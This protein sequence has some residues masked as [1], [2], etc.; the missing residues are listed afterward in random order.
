MIFVS[1]G[2][3][4]K[5]FKRLLDAIEKQIDKGNIKEEV[6]VQ[7]GYTKYKSDNMKIFDL[8]SMEDFQKYMSSCDLLI[9]HGGVGSILDGLKHNKKIIAAPRLKEFGEHT[10]DHQL[11]IINS[12]YEKGYIL[13][14]E[15]F[16][17]LDKVLL[18]VKSFKPKKFVFNNENFVKKIKEYIDS[19]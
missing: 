15:D 19:N 9:T 13:K 17:K 10:N 8:V 6:I 1:L 16:D 12:F 14:L 5:S 2:T 18:E 3:Q 7:A 11:Q 4:D